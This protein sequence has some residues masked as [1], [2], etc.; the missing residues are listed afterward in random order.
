MEE[1]PT[2]QDQPATLPGMESYAVDAPPNRA[3]SPSRLH[4]DAVPSIG[5]GLS[6]LRSMM[7]GDDK[8]FKNMYQTG[9]LK[10]N[11]NERRMAEKRVFGLDDSVAPEDR[12]VYGYLRDT[13]TP[14]ELDT[15]AGYGGEDNVQLDLRAPTED[16]RV[17]T[18][19]GDTFG[20]NTAEP[21]TPEIKGKKNFVSPS[22]RELQYFDHPTTDDIV[23]AAVHDNYAG[24]PDSPK[25]E[26]LDALERINAARRADEVRALGIPTRHLANV[27]QPSLFENDPDKNLHGRNETRT[28][29]SGLT[30]TATPE[31]HEASRLA[32]FRRAFPTPEPIEPDTNYEVVPRDPNKVLG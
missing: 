6:T 5:M 16:E 25:R 22:Y 11:D 14:S 4:K 15:L 20:A 13:D 24:L 8:E 31:E 29:S 9:N 27:Y 18:S 1:R 10:H 28:L 19:D 30:Q 7:T 32:A 21:L 17:F 23:G 3:K 12:P 2:F 26:A